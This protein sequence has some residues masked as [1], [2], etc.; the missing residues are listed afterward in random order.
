MTAILTQGIAWSL[1][2]L[3]ADLKCSLTSTCIYVIW[4]VG[5]TRGRAV[6]RE[7]AEGEGAEGE[8]AEGEGAEGEGAEGEGAE[9]GGRGKELKWCKNC[10]L[11]SFSPFTYH[12]NNMCWS[13]G[14]A[15]TIKVR[16]SLGVPIGEHGCVHVHGVDSRVYRPT[17]REHLHRSTRTAGSLYQAA[18]D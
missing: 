10:C 1:P 15:L 16:V 5:Y 2:I 13:V 8:G 6:K 17:P 9:W 7:G 14:H 18:G 3:L 12:Y 4:G 11:F